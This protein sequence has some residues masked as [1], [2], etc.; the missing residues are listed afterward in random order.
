MS[1][2]AMLFLVLD[3]GAVGLETGANPIRKVVTLMQNMQ[4]EIEATGAKEKELFD[5]FMCYCSNNNGALGKAIEDGKAKIEELTAKQKSEEAE[6]SQNEQ[7]LIQ[8]KKDR[9]AAAADLSEATSIREKE[10]KEFA[11]EKADSETNIKA[12]AGAIPALEAGMGG[13]SLLQTPGGSRLQK[14]VASFPFSDE[15]DRRH[16]VA[17]FEQSGDYVPQSGQ[18]VG[19][20]KQMKEE[21]EGSLAQATADEEKAVAGFGELKASKEQEQ[22]VATKAIE[23]KQ[24]RAGDLAVSVVQV[25]ND[26]EDTEEEVAD[27]EKFAKTLESECGTKEKEWAE[28]E[29][30]RAEEIAAISDAIGILNDDDALDVFKKAIPASALIA[31]ERAGFLQRSVSAATRLGRAQSILSMVA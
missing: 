17:F 21:M 10:A 9:E 15:M 26:I 3:T 8:H 25:A 11:E 30:L 1:R 22:A 20:L 19:I 6:K 28:R 7:D 31:E 16:V 12:M 29:K 24:T 14:L 23:T 13:A 5:K 27:T 18:I 2:S 4:K